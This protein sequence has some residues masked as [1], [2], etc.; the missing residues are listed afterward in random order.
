MDRTASKFEVTRSPIARKMPSLQ[1]FQVMGFHSAHFISSQPRYDH[2]DTSPYSLFCINERFRVSPVMTASIPLHM[3]QR[4][5]RFRN[6]IFTTIRYYT[7]GA[8][9]LQA[10]LAQ[11]GS[12]ITCPCMEHSYAV[13]YN[14][15]SLCFLSPQHC[16]PALPI[17]HHFPHQPIEPLRM[18]RMHKMAQFMQHNVFSRRTGKRYEPRVECD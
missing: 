8:H 9:A 10:F 6:H 13:P 11:V 14:A 15:P 3:H 4:Q 7:T 1:G 16:L 12:E 5:D 17:R 2:F 18:V